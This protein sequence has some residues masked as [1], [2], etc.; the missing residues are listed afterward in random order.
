VER[1]SCEN[2]TFSDYYG[3]DFGGIFHVVRYLS[4][5]KV[6]KMPQSSTG[7]GLLGFP[8]G[9]PSPALR[10]FCT[11]APPY[12]S[13]KHCLISGSALAFQGTV[14]KLPNMTAFKYGCRS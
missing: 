8:A 9:G 7:S 6:E 5:G 2:T 13:Q 4:S 12:A 11:H 10:G 1:Q 14:L 3:C